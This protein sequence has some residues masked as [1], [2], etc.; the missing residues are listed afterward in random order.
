MANP[1]Q[2]GQP[3]SEKIAADCPTRTIVKVS[4]NFFF[5]CAEM[6]FPCK[7][8]VVPGRLMPVTSAAARNDILQRSIPRIST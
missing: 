2:T 8:F 6:S 7:T 1:Q 4:P 3:P 5:R